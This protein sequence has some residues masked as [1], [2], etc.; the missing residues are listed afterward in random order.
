M[1][2]KYKIIS[3]FVIMILLLA[4]AVILGYLEIQNSSTGFSA[5]RRLARL[6]VAVSDTVS[7]LNGAASDVN[8]YMRTRNEQAIAQADARLETASAHLRT[9]L[10]FSKSESTKQLMQELLDNVPVI[11]GMHKQVRESV[12]NS[13]TLYQN[14]VTPSVEHM[15]VRLMSLTAQAEQVDNLPALVQISK[16]WEHFSQAASAINRFA[17]T[18]VNEDGESA[19]NAL[20]RMG[21]TLDG[22]SASLLTT[23]GKQSFDELRVAFDTLSSTFGDMR[24][25]GGIVESS[26]ADMVRFREASLAKANA[27]NAD[28]GGRM[29]QYGDDM[30]KSNEGAQQYMVELGAVGIVMGLAIAMVI[31]I[32]I[33]RVLKEL[34]R[35]ASSVAQ[36]NFSYQVNNKEKGEIGSMVA[37]MQ[38]IPAV[39][40]RVIVLANTMAEDIRTGNLRERLNQ[41]ELPGAFSR[42]GLAINTVSDAYTQIIDALPVPIM[43]CDTDF[44]VT[45]Y[46]KTGQ[47]VVGGNHVGSP[48]REHLKSGECGSAACFGKRAIIDQRVITGETEAMPQQQRKNVALTAMPLCNGKG[49]PAGCLE[50]FIDLTE[51]RTQE[52][53]M[54]TVARQALSIADRVAAA[55]EELAA[56]VEEISR[57]AEIQRSRVESTASA[58]MEMNATVLEVARNACKASE[59]SGGTKDKAENGSGLVNRVVD[60]IH[61][62]N[63]V[64]GAMQ[65]NMQGL[66]QQA[67]SIGGVMN[68]ISD[69]ADQTNLLALNAAIEAARAGDAGRGFAVV[70]DEVRKLAEKTMA[71]T[72]EVGASINAIQQSARVNMGEVENAVLNM[73]QAAQLANASGEA[74]NEI[75]ELASENSVVVASIATAAEQQSA[76][77][78]E[79]NSAIE[80]INRITGETTDGMVQSSA[81]V[82]ELSRMSQELKRVIEELR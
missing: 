16:V 37:A 63:S 80:E 10:S 18:H 61:Q 4:A 65:H 24:K 28:I 78:E 52:A 64:G 67:E 72:H 71:A 40:G 7:A 62:I 57:G 73:E 70:A 41:E 35:F 29:V 56:Q 5:Y 66:G 27:F 59:Q 36:G 25:A 47:D 13:S 46:N 54:A 6:D 14:T 23:A 19:K 53:T 79:I 12:L 8:L 15:A 43:T 17:V 38:E 58:M 55:S 31:V 51:I 9:A 34:S 49:E 76:T 44:N 60:A 69:I 82:Q 75:V 26:L 39:L 1:T 2:T 33:I 42:L 77:S 30:L 45:F 74:L 32:G 20:E 81:A 68:V 21:K 3:G 22:L 11:A 50:V 48:C